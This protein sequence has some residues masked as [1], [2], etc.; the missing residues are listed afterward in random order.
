[1]MLFARDHGL[2][3]DVAPLADPPKRTFRAEP[4]AAAGNGLAARVDRLERPRAAAVRRVVEAELALERVGGLVHLPARGPVGARRRAEH[5][6]VAL[7]RLAHLLAGPGGAR[8]RDVVLPADVVPGVDAGLEAVAAHR[9]HQRR[10]ARAD[11]RAG[12]QRAV[13]QRADSVVLD[14]RGAR[15]LLQE[16]APEHAP[17]RA[18]G[19]V[20]PEAEQE[21]GSRCVAL[22]QPQQWRDPLA[23]AAPGV[24]VDLQRERRHAAVSRPG[25][26]RPRSGCGSG[27]RSSAARRASRPSAPSRG[28]PSCCRSSARGSAR[29]GSPCRNRRRRW[30]PRP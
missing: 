15:H 30:S 26:A 9:A 27:R 25:R 14:H 3:L 29:P 13:E 5:L 28:R 17:D 2:A 24:D 1:M 8:E 23:R 22:E 11:V 10:L 4:P 7:D 21:G 19:V 16:P 6:G 20:G 12:Q 18:S